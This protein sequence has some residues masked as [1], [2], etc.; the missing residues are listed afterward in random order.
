M[1]PCGRSTHLYY[2]KFFSMGDVNPFAYLFKHLCQCEF[3]DLYFKFGVVTSCY[4]VQSVLALATRDS[5][6]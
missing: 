6:S 4:T 5:L 2:L 3:M 1:L